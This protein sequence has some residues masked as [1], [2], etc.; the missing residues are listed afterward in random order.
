MFKIYSTLFAKNI[1]QKL[2]FFINKTI[3]NFQFNYY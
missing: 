3:K 1:N 2:K